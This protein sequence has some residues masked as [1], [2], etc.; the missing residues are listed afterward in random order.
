MN[1]DE[2]INLTEYIKI[3]RKRAF[4]FAVTSILIIAGGIAYTL[5]QTPVYEAVTKLE[6]LDTPEE[7]MEILHSFGGM[8]NDRIET[9][10]E[11][12]RSRDIARTV[13]E[14]LSL[15][16]DIIISEGNPDIIISEAASAY[17]VRSRSAVFFLIFDKN[18]GF[19]V[20]DE[21]RNIVAEGTEG[22]FEH[23]AVS[24]NITINK[25]GPGDITRITVHHIESAVDRLIKQTSV[26][27][28]GDT[29]IIR[30]AVQHPSPETA[31]D[32]VSEFANVYSLKTLKDKNVSACKI[33]KFASERQEFYKKKKVE[34]SEKLQDFKEKHNIFSLDSKNSSLITQMAEMESVKAVKKVELD[35]IR[36]AHAMISSGQG[37]STTPEIFPPQSGLEQLSARLSMLRVHKKKLLN[38]LTTDHPKVVETEVQIAEIKK[39]IEKK[40]TATRQ[41]VQAELDSIEKHM[42]S[43]DDQIKELPQLDKEMVEKI[44]DVKF[45]EEMELQMAKKAEEFAILE[46]STLSSVRTVQE[47]IVPDSPVRPKRLINIILTFIIS[48]VCG[49]GMVFLT[50]YLDNTFNSAEEVEE[51]LDEEV[52]VVI[53]YVRK[54]FSKDVY[55]RPK[56]GLAYLSADSPITE[57]FRTL[58]TSIEFMDLGKKAKVFQ[59]S[60][61]VAG[62]GKSMISSN[63]AITFAN[64]GL[65]TLL[66]DADYKKPILDRIL[67]CENRLGF[68]DMIYKGISARETIQHTEIDN[69]EFIPSGL[70]LDGNMQSIHYEKLAPILDELKHIYEYVFIDTPPILAIDDSTRI[71][72]IADGLMLVVSL[73]NVERHAVSRCVARCRNNGINI[74][75]VIANDCEKTERYTRSYNYFNYYPY[76]SQRKPAKSVEKKWRIYLN[77]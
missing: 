38:N 12:L 9:E 73:G 7:E 75:G 40:L 52:V 6:I 68:I 71:A 57:A 22:A 27:R 72:R 32:I 29:S 53:P 3:V 64:S 44:R 55:T 33:N 63:L 11:K 66:I 65:R 46:I 49:L 51:F 35:R 14:N 20:T 77:K 15:Y 69:L 60:S 59:I 17:A 47:P 5:L 13:A 67:K 16:S 30:I 23:P 70:M 2:D 8:H 37:E 48:L 74:T 4:L 24:F 58:K 45:Y 19:K 56:E 62:E 10:I 21:N 76:T 36:N 25:A 42:S 34:A 50:E 43:Y 41:A 39:T 18:G 28:I 31:A 1:T 54:R 26:S 61:S